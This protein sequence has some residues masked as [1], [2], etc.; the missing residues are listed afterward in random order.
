MW[1]ATGGTIIP[2]V[3]AENWGQQIN[4]EDNNMNKYRNIRNSSRSSENKLMVTKA[5]TRSMLALLALAWED[6]LV[7]ISMVA[8]DGNY[9]LITLTFKKYGNLPLCMENYALFSLPSIFKSRLY[10]YASRYIIYL[11]ESSVIL[12]LRLPWH[13]YTLIHA[14]IWS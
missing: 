8:I 5:S 7:S 10:T 11:G 4:M 14:L 3:C 12:N 2:P 13:I 1:S 6:L 9:W